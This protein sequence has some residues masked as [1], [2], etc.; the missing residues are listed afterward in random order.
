MASTLQHTDEI[1]SAITAASGC[2]SSTVSALQ[3]LLGLGA[4]ADEKK[5][6]PAPKP[7]ARRPTR[8]D[9]LLS[10][11]DPSRRPRIEVKILREDSAPLSPE[12][13]LVFATQAINAS[14]KA[15][16][17][18]VRR[19]QS[20]SPS[21]CSPLRKPDATARPAS[22]KP[23][24][25]R[26]LNSPDKKDS[27]RITCQNGV[28]GQLDQAGVA[29]VAD[30]A[31]MA[32]DF[33][34]RNKK[35]KT[36]AV[37][38][39]MENAALAFASKYIALGLDSY[40]VRELRGVKRRL[41]RSLTTADEQRSATVPEKEP[42]PDLLVYQ[43]P[44]RA[45]EPI[46]PLIITQQY[47]TAKLICLR[48]KPREIEALAHHL[49]VR[50]QYS[51]LRLLQQVPAKPEARSKHLK[52]LE[53]LSSTL[54]SVGPSL[55]V[56]A[57]GV[58]VDLQQHPSPDKVFDLQV[59]ALRTRLESWK[60]STSSVMLE[61]D[62]WLPLA[63]FLG[64]FQR[65][66][67]AVCDQKFARAKAAFTGLVNLLRGAKINCNDELQVP[68]KWDT[69]RVMSSLAQEGG[70][71]A[72]GVDYA[73]K[74][75]LLSLPA[76][77]CSVRKAT[78]TIRLAT[79]MLHGRLE[80]QLN[81][82]IRSAHAS[83][84]TESLQGH[85]TDL[86]LLLLEVAGYRR[87]LM[88]AFIRENEPSGKAE[89]ASLCGLGIF[90]CA[91]FLLRYLGSFPDEKDGEKVR[92]RYSEKILRVRK[93]APGFLDSVMYCAKVGVKS[94]SVDWDQLDAVLQDSLK[95]ILDLDKSNSL[96]GEPPI[97]K[98]KIQVGVSTLY[99]G[100]Y[101]QRS[102]SSIPDSTAVQSLQRCVEVLE[103]ADKAARTAGMLARRLEMLAEV[104][105]RN[106]QS[107]ESHRRYQHALQEHIDTG[108]L[109]SVARRA[110]CMSFDAAWNSAD[111]LSLSRCIDGVQSLLWKTDL[112]DESPLD[113]LDASHLDEECRGVILER[114]LWLFSN[115]VLKPS[116]RVDDC[117][118]E[119]L[120]R[121]MRSLF[122]VFDQERFPIRRRRAALLATYISLTGMDI[123]EDDIKS[124]VLEIAG[125]PQHPE[126]S[127]DINLIPYLDHLHASLQTNLALSQ[128]LT[129][130]NDITSAL[131]T[132]QSI[133]DSQS[134][135]TTRIDGLPAF[136]H[137]LR[138]L[139][140]F[141][142]V[143]CLFSLRIST[144]SLL[145]RTVEAI[146]KEGTA[147][148][149]CLSALSLQCLR[150]GYS[151]QADLVLAKC[152]NVVDTA[153][154]SVDAVVGHYLAYSE[155]FLCIGA[156]E[157]W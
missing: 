108:L 62:F 103:F 55:S 26:S 79:L 150:A 41:E 151:G 8:K 146:D 22:K 76:P 29:A 47:Y 87:A 39:Q 152:Q 78:I 51:T 88:N 69:Y 3:D 84:I 6:Q 30:C 27:W 82:Q 153:S 134:D 101:L 68:S 66:S 123:V 63:R 111:G 95:L 141:L 139:A 93:A 74:A 121:V 56:N 19:K 154:P 149:E 10:K 20:N 4:I 28:G 58:A 127:R 24:Q 75:S 17:E 70:N 1:I 86:D 96:G 135:L 129:N 49:D 61:K 46:A 90:N 114:Q 52:Q 54:F 126:K 117:L 137:Q 157:K 65:R 133:G 155:Y 113:F 50:H 35:D 83:L 92:A 115:E 97:G 42:I 18:A 31:T 36:D 118:K 104:C 85:S 67:A 57:D 143:Q 60:L 110:S 106:H 147:L 140:D 72:D 100:Y 124:L 25:P 59:L 102:K 5:R 53:S 107:A 45:A 12:A 15:L 37:D 125:R 9:V 128:P 99:S 131:S 112:T 132:W 119:R 44:G 33:A 145:V 64:A 156:T 116:R 122:D 40:A 80:N 73:K 16:S 77:Q 14:L 136:A 109:E 89:L 138:L 120:H 148:A 32:M 94:Q 2:S 144:L 105:E 130:I 91:R 13:R 34:R 21:S 81:E 38:I 142:E 7:T 48:K 71:I 11:Q 43:D 98:S 23:L